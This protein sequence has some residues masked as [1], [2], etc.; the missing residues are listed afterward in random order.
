MRTNISNIGRLAFG[1]TLTAMV[2]LIA[3]SEMAT[4]QENRSS[5]K[6]QK[7]GDN[8]VRLSDKE[9][10]SF[11]V[12]F[13]S[14]TAQSHVAFVVE[15]EPLHPKLPENEVPNVSSGGERLGALVIKLADAYDY[16]V[17]QDGKVF[18]LCK[19]YTDPHDLPCVTLDECRLAIEDVKRVT[20]VFNPHVPYYRSG[21]SN[22]LVSDLLDTLTPEQLSLMHDRQL[23]VS[24]LTPEQQSLA[25][26]TALYIY[27]QL[28]VES[29]NSSLL[30]LQNAA[31]ATFCHGIRMGTAFFG[32]TTPPGKPESLL[33]SDLLASQRT[34]N[35]P[36]FHQLSSPLI[37]TRRVILTHGRASLAPSVGVPI[38]STLGKGVTILN[39]RGDG[40]LITVDPALGPKP[41][42][43]I[44]AENAR[45]AAIITALTD[46]YGLRVVTE[47]TGKRRLTRP[48]FRVPLDISGIPDAVRAV[49]PAPMVRALSDTEPETAL[50]QQSA[51][52]GKA[53]QSRWP[54][55]ELK[56]PSS[57][58][59]K[60]LKLAGKKKAPH[61]LH[62]LHDAAVEEL[63]SAVEPQIRAASDGRV[64]EAAV[65][66][67]SSRA[68]ATI[69]MTQCLGD[70]QHLMEQNPP[71]YIADFNQVML[72]G[73][74]GVSDDGR[75]VITLS[76]GQPLRNGK[77][78]EGV[79]ITHFISPNEAST[80]FHR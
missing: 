49:F 74:P 42:T 54:S 10:G 9:A 26:R 1:V 18:I 14:L 20:D 41:V 79:G 57:K 44:G 25:R 78:V 40:S 48:L 17:K 13:N 28:P 27:V 75:A 72:C 22:P 66:E 6:D 31:Q 73:G 7:T 67:A 45:T 46:I 80:T 69:L 32:Y 59:E 62:A 2:L 71:Y 77:T 23:P 51:A 36:V 11:A 63:V 50:P 70:L 29:S 24:S 61:S 76:F 47:D 30:R 60:P 65:P 56:R 35:K 21:S 64:P 58:S 5:N 52:E 53:S 15:G 16:D 38:S 33:M 55:E 8:L 39:K 68:F 4:S 43:V 12:A 34:P 19:R 3:S 37:P